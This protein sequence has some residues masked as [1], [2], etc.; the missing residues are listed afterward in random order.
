MVSRRQAVISLGAAVLAVPLPSFG[1]QRPAK[2]PRVGY[3]QPVVP[4][5]D[6]SPFLEDFRQ[7]LRELGYVEGKNLQLEIRW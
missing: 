5:N 4:E 1:Q 3:L 6:S 2:I 7:G